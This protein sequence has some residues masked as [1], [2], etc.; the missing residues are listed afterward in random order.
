[1]IKEIFHDKRLSTNY[2]TTRLL[3]V[4]MA[5]GEKHQDYNFFSD[6]ILP[7]LL[8]LLLSLFFLNNIQQ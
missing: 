7:N 1:M 4:I 3:R 6:K 8:F 5:N 2:P